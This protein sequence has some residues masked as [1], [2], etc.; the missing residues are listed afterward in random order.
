MGHGSGIA[1]GYAEDRGWATTLL[2]TPFGCQL[3]AKDACEG[4][5]AGID[6]RISKWKAQGMSA[7]GKSMA[8]KVDILSKLTFLWHVQVLPKPLRVQIEGRPARIM[9][10]RRGCRLALHS[11]RE[12]GGL[13]I[14]CGTMV[15]PRIMLVPNLWDWVLKAI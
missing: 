3:Q 7:L 11:S 10:G 8:T 9:W 4:T 5:L 14:P 12:N 15:S 6:E 13:G 2:G 1:G